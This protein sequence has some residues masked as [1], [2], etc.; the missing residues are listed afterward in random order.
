MEIFAHSSESQEYFLPAWDF[1]PTQFPRLNSHALPSLALWT[2]AR[3]TK[4]H[5]AVLIC[6][7]LKRKMFNNCK[8]EKLQIRVEQEVEGKTWCLL[9]LLPYVERETSSGCCKAEELQNEY[10]KQHISIWDPIMFQ[11]CLANCP[12]SLHLSK[13]VLFCILKVQTSNRKGVKKK[14]KLE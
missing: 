13:N 8:S 10:R 6:E 7:L 12:S 1:W 3:L 4:D 2:S 9:R 14:K 5:D 11:F